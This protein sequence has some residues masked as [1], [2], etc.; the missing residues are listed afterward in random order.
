M[1]VTVALNFL[2]CS[3]GIVSLAY[4]NQSMI[5]RQDRYFDTIAYIALHTL[6]VKDSVQLSRGHMILTW[7]G[8][9]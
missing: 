5:S 4:F 8:T 9:R 2:D 6:N 1:F 3:G 7:A